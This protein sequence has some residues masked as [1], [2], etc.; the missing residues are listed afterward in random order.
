MK[1]IF[2][3]S[4]SVIATGLQ[5][6]ETL[7]HFNEVLLRG[8]ILEYVQRRGLFSR[9][10]CPRELLSSGDRGNVRGDGPITS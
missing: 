8:G 10:D 2:R 4:G 5:I 9:G 1:L 7:F 3:L 6:L